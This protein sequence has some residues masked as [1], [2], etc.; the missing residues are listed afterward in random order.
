MN[1]NKKFTDKIYDLEQSYP[2][3]KYLSEI[4]QPLKIVTRIG[5]KTN[6]TNINDNFLFI[7]IHLFNF[8]I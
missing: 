5:S 7:V 8:C 4:K 2:Q 3:K 6:I 1:I